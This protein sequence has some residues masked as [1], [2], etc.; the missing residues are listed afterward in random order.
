MSLFF[1]PFPLCLWLEFYDKMSFLSPIFVCLYCHATFPES[2]STKAR[3][4]GKLKWWPGLNRLQPNLISW[5]FLSDHCYLQPTRGESNKPKTAR[6][7]SH[8]FPHGRQWN[9]WG[10]WHWKEIQ[11]NSGAFSLQSMC[12]FYQY[13]YFK[14]FRIFL[15]DET[16]QL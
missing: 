11:G 4:W 2:I 1:H 6:Q 8:A 15:L 9:S 12:V 5:C 13:E 10:V 7:E 16:L 3:L 14:L